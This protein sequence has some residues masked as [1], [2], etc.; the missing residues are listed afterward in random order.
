MRLQKSFSGIK[1]TS[2]FAN[3]FASL[4]IRELMIGNLMVILAGLLG[5]LTGFLTYIL[6]DETN[7]RDHGR[8]KDVGND[9]SYHL[10]GE[11]SS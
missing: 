8:P 10:N 5:Y 9:A 4:R 3:G 7:G 1:K 11:F 2:S 6:G